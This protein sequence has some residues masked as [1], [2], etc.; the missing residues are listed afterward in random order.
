MKTVK[1][2]MIATLLVFT[3]VSLTNADGFKAKP[4]SNI[5]YL[6]VAQALEVPGLAAVMIRQLNPGFLGCRCQSI[7]SQR[8]IFLKVTYVI[9]GTEQEWESFFKWGYLLI[10]EDHE[11]VTKF[12]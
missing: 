1:I 8:V 7:Y 6:T 2:I 10:S 9:S 4:K 11:A 3:T 5:I 12:D